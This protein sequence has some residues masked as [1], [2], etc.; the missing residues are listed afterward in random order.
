MKRHPRIKICGITRPEDA[1]RAAELGADAIGLVFVERSPRC[2]TVE[3]AREIC[4]ALPPLVGAVGLFMDA[5][6]ERVRSIAGAVPLNW[7]QFHGSESDAYC[8]AFSRPWIKAVPMGETQRPD[9]SA[10]PGADALLLD[11]HEAGGL[12]GTGR[13]FD[14]QRLSRPD[15]PWILAGG[16]NPENVREAVERLDPPAI[17]VSSGVES[18]P[19]IKDGNLMSRLIEGA[20]NG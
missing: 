4:R 20:R 5:E 19:G 12:G 10:W 9:F 14:W 16:L 17:D 13:R 1:R 2:V 8:R 18:S 15:R 6:P 11:A 3:V 7:L